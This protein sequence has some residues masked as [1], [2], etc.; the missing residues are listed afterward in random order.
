MTPSLKSVILT[1]MAIAVLHS[2][3]AQTDYATDPH[4][5]PEVRAFLKLVNGGG[6]PV[7][8]LSK[9]D[10]RNVL[11]NAQNS[12]KVDLSGI[13]E[14]EKTIQAN[15]HSIKLNI[16][17]PAG[18]K[19]VLPVFIFIHGGGWILGDYPTHKRMVR[20]LVVLSGC[21][22]VFVNYTPSP[23][24]HYPVAINEIYEATKWVAEHGAEINADGKKLAVVGNSVGG[25]MT[26]V[27]CLM[28]KAKNGPK[29]S[30]QI[31][32]WPIVDAG[33]D[34]ESYKLFGADRF[35]TTPLIKWMY[36]QYTPDLAQRKEIYASP[37]Q[38][39][40]DQL[41]GLPPAL[42]QVAENDVL[43]DEGEAYGR[44]LEEAGVKATTV[45]Y[46]GVIHD[47]GLLN[48]LAEIPQTRALFVQAAAELR[49][50]LK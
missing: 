36:D 11:V 48:G 33:F 1:I 26:A 31:M 50:Y 22:G 38:A 25:N 20:D 30:L 6:P 24:A 14:S 37:L 45:R 41:K 39:S 34:T 21:Q 27:T 47:F 8:S 43:R 46:N 15:G 32:M 3:F 13:E 23:E 9:E 12:V 2:A 35:L 4:L 16:V 18:A 10:A 28:A 17:R 44:K 40:V 5:T 7:E 19:G 29:I 42:I 49:K